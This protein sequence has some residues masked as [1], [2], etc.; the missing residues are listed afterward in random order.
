MRV[1]DVKAAG[2]GGFEKSKPVAMLFALAS[3]EA[4]GFSPQLS[5]MKRRIDVKSSC[6]WSTSRLE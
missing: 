4:S 5:S 3:R 2:R 1:A 6:V